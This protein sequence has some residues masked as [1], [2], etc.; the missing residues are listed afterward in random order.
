M[1]RHITRRELLTKAAPTA[2]VLVT[3]SELKASGTVAA[4]YHGVAS[5]DPTQT[6][7]IIWTRVTTNQQ[8]AEVSWQVS[9]DA[10]FSRT[11]A[12]GMVLTDADSDYTVKVD[13]D[14]LQAGT[15]YFY[16][17]NAFEVQSITGRTRTLPSGD[18]ASFKMGVCSCSNYPSG[19]FNAY[20]AMSALDDLDIVVHLGDYIYEYDADGYASQNAEA[21]G[22]ISEPMHEVTRLNDF[23]RRH[24]QYKADA[25]LQALHA[26]HPFILSWDDH[27]VSNDAWANG[28]ENHDPGEGDWSQ[29]KAAALQAY[30]EWMPIRPPE[31]RDRTK[32]W[33]NF[34]FGNLASLTMLETRLSA[35]DEQIEVSQHMVFVNAKFDVGDAENPVQVGDDAFGMHIEVVSLPFD[36]READPKPLLDYKRIKAMQA[37]EA[38]PKGWAYMPDVKRFSEQLLGDP[39]RQLLGEEQRTFVAGALKKS[40]AS[41]KRWQ[42]IGNQTLVAQVNTP[43]LVKALS[44]EEKEGLSK[45][46]KPALPWTQLGLPFGT[47]SWNGYTAEREWLLSEAAKNAA[48]LV[49]LTG[50]THAAWAFDLAPKQGDGSWQGIELGC[51]SISSPG[52]PE[53]IGVNAARLSSLMREANPN[54]RYSEPAHRGF[55]TLELTKENATAEFHQ[56]STIT[57][58][59]F[60]TSSNDQFQIT[61]RAQNTGIELKKV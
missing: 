21:M 22:R 59:T 50:D 23:R 20:A 7:V 33:R 43:N 24:G 40:T 35:R 61:S 25:S 53:A 4:F 1:P 51:T 60:S 18:V 3:A 17:F 52:L 8:Q 15:E 38:L 32:Q 56:V 19:Y 6:Q 49:V 54:L 29:R 5:G 27:E 9:T 46:I 26:K 37:L 10:D 36:F 12:A 14:S 47:D 48:N 42:I 57:E 30:Y 44:A 13:V 39:D 28:A 58:K 2:A 11:V 31:G 41:G 34:E 16:R 55:L 45:W